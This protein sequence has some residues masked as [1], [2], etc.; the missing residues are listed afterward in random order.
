MI[1]DA[2][3]Q[4]KFLN[5][6]KQG[7]RARRIDWLLHVLLGNVCQYYMHA[8]HAVNVQ[9]G[10]N[11]AMEN[12]VRQAVA[13]AQ[14][15]FHLEM[16]EAAGEAVKIK[17]CSSEVVHKVTRPG[18]PEAGCDCNFFMRGNICKHII[19]VKRC[20]VSMT[21]HLQKDIITLS[22]TVPSIG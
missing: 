18:T 5:P 12:L 1:C 15:D 6:A 20:I 14:A 19:K 11:K 9:H 22:D 8:E 3:L 10:Y 21:G 16:P 7:M 4:E 13:N 17:S 2:N